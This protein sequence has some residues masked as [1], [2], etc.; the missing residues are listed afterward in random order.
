M[1][2]IDNEKLQA[3]LEYYLSEPQQAM[4]YYWHLHKHMAILSGK[5]VGKTGWVAYLLIR[6]SFNKKHTYW[7]IGR[8]YDI[9]NRVWDELLSHAYK[10]GFEIDKK[11]NRITNPFSGSVIEAKS[12]N[13]GYQHLRG[14][15]LHGVVVDE[16]IL[17]QSKA[18]DSDLRPNLKTTNGWSVLISNAPISSANWFVKKYQQYK[19][20]YNKSKEVGKD[21]PYIA[22]HFTSYDSPFISKEALDEERAIVDKET[23]EREYLAMPPDL[24][25]EVFRFGLKDFFT[26]TK[27]TPPEKEHRRRYFA[28]LD[29]ARKHDEPVLCI[30]DRKLKTAIRFY[31]F[32]KVPAPDLE[33]VVIEKLKLWK[34]YKLI[35]DETGGGFYL[36]D[37]F[38]QKLRK[39]GILVRGM[40]L[41]GGKKNLIIDKLVSRIENWEIQAVD[42]PKLKHQM[43]VFTIKE[44]PSGAISYTAPKGEFDDYVDALA[45]ANYE[46]LC[47]NYTVE[48][49]QKTISNFIP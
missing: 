20:I 23:F 40:S 18:F 15:S 16:A 43:E 14:K 9:T 8:S 37:H 38:K 2:V 42:D 6:E 26:R 28:V 33:N 39:D 21:S 19:S 35:V 36:V 12:T 45:I 13:N 48:H 11:N 7:V 32:E 17:L 29:P 3:Q 49:Q 44:L 34:C 1:K 25:G 24:R 22:L 31:A 41:A 27:F 4:D 47:H 46:D 30:W 10:L 5:R